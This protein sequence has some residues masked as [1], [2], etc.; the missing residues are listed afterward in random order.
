LWSKTHY[1]KRAASSQQEKKH[2]QKQWE[3]LGVPLPQSV[4]DFQLPYCM[5]VEP[6]GDV[7]IDDNTLLQL[8]DNIEMLSRQ[9]PQWHQSFGQRYYSDLSFFLAS[10]VF[11]PSGAVR[12]KFAIVRDI[13]TT[14][15]RERLDRILEE[16]P[17][18][19]EELT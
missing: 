17:D 19:H 14:G 16:L 1:D 5:H 10:L 6:E 3:N 2:L 12:M 15:N 13:L 11:G 18:I 4:I 9:F 8:G 7:E